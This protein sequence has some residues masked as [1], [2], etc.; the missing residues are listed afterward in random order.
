[1]GKNQS[2]R[3]VKAFFL[4]RA[5]ETAERIA[6]GDLTPDE[7]LRAIAAE[8]LK[9]KLEADQTAKA[10]AKQERY[11]ARQKRGR[12]ERLRRIAKT[13]SRIRRE[14][15]VNN[16]P[17]EWGDPVT[18]RNSEICGP[19]PYGPNMLA[20]IANTYKRQ[21]GMCP[22]C[23]RVQEQ[24]SIIYGGE[25]ERTL[26]TSACVIAPACHVLQMPGEYPAASITEIRAEQVGLSLPATPLR[27][28]KSPPG[29][30]LPR[31]VCLACHNGQR[32]RRLR[33]VHPL[34]QA[35]MLDE[36][37]ALKEH[38][39]QCLAELDALDCWTLT[40]CNT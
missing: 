36:A 37:I 28:S 29:L 13:L 2:K 30:L 24:Q 23:M 10:S 33:E 4:R 15:H 21:D 18:R 19:P 27:F 25:R 5:K 40:E 26:Y 17:G 39:A 8:A 35:A 12:T 31:V 1:M 3:E 32:T 14:R 34:T 38:S 11:R 20:L 9:L 22:E 7:R 6:R 16:K